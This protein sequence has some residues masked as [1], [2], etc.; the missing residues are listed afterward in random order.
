MLLSMWMLSNR[1]EQLNPERHFPRNVP[2][3][4]RSA[5]LHYAEHCVH[6]YAEGDDVVCRD[7]EA[8]FVLK[9][10]TTM[11][12]L[13]LLQDTFDFFQ[14][15]DASFQE[16]ALNHDLQRIINES[17]FLFHNP[18]LLSDCSHK[19]LAMS[20]Q[21]EDDA[22]TPEWTYTANH[23]HSSVEV[24][25]IMKRRAPTRRFYLDYH[26]KYYS[27]PDDG[28]MSRLTQVIYF[29]DTRIGRIS[30]FEYERQMNEGDVQ[31]LEYLCMYLARAMKH[32]YTQEKAFAYN[33]Y[34]DLIYG[35]MPT[36]DEIARQYAYMAWT[37]G[38][39]LIVY[40]LSVRKDSLFPVI[41]RNVR[42]AIP[43]ANIFYEGDKAIVICNLAACK[44]TDIENKLVRIA[45]EHQLLLAASLPFFDICMLKYYYRQCC[46]SL[47]RLSDSPDTGVRD[48]LEDAYAFILASDD[49]QQQVHA[50]HPAMAQLFFSPLPEKQAAF[51]LLSFY[52]ASDCSLNQTAAALN[53]HRNTLSYR[54]NKLLDETGLHLDD[55]AMRDY[56]LLSSRVLAEIS[57]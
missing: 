49:L 2:I 19:K 44:R 48:F 5:R 39:P 7:Q 46:W 27:F 33:M 54:L 41:I 3:H 43:S 50:V 56:L 23:G 18:I 17:W 36:Q 53:L 52:L 51:H 34:L 35:A 13:E 42:A 20:Q 32:L 11:E 57:V 8:W 40:V 31:L 15:Q 45:G 9:N 37:I 29:Q 24:I 1:L 25:R 47:N 12:A 6:I 10:M 22:V 16:A 30:V 28:L 4:L 14:D 55:P 38:D 26:A 21:Y